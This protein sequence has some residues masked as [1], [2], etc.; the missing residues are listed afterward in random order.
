MPLPINSALTVNTFHAALPR[1]IA[2]SASAALATAGTSEKSV[3]GTSYASGTP[4]WKASM[5]TK[6]IDQM[7]MPIANAPE[8]SH[9][10]AARR[11]DSVTRDPSSSAVNDAITAIK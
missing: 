4:R 1:R 5:P 8:I 3:V 6:C 11:S 7:P 9:T 10:R 2:E